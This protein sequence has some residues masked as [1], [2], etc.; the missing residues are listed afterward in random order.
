MEKRVLRQSEY[1]IKRVEILDNLKNID[2]EIFK[3]YSYVVDAKEIS[4]EKSI[5]IH[6][7]LCLLSAVI[8]NVAD[9]ITEYGDLLKDKQ[10]KDALCLAAGAFLNLGLIILNPGL[11]LL[12]TSGLMVCTHMI[13]NNKDLSLFQE[14]M[15]FLKESNFSFKTTMDNCFRFAAAKRNDDVRENVFINDYFVIDPETKTVK[16]NDIMLEIDKITKEIELMI[17][18]LLK[19]ITNSK[20]NDISALLMA[21]NESLQNGRDDLK[22][23]RTPKNVEK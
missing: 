16:I 23:V 6:V 14:D 17:V 3:I 9:D 22:F 12:T 4:R 18:I 11:G 1:E 15:N 21:M 10:K 2:K 7:K 13:K 5:L 20:E 8:S 19:E